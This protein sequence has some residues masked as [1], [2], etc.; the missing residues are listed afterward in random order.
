MVSSKAVCVYP[1][2][3]SRHWCPHDGHS[4]DGVHLITGATQGELSGA[5]KGS[6]L[7]CGHEIAWSGH[8]GQDITNSVWS[9]ALSML[10]YPLPSSPSP[11]PPSPLPPCVSTLIHCAWPDLPGL[12]PPYLHPASD[13]VGTIEEQGYTG[14]AVGVSSCWMVTYTYSHIWQRYVFAPCHGWLIRDVIW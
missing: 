3:S 6:S 4:G 14:L 5:R 2:A 13:Q 10:S 9:I 12:P 1:I 8:P 7:G 11:L